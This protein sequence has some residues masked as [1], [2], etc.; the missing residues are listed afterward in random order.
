MIDFVAILAASITVIGV[1]VI[2]AAIS[3]SMPQ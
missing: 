2:Y 3:S 1:V